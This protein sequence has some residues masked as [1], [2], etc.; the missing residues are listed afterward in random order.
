MYET[1]SWLQ[2]AFYELVMKADKGPSL[3]T[4]SCMQANIKNYR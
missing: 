1:K 4:K 2:K 3:T